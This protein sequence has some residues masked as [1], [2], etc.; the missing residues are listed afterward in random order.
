MERL[1]RER[2]TLSR[3]L[4]QSQEALEEFRELH[5]SE[6]SVA[7]EREQDLVADNAALRDALAS[8][9]EELHKLRDAF[10]KFLAVREAH[11]DAPQP[12]ADPAW[13]ANAFEQEYDSEELEQDAFET[14][15][16]QAQGK[17]LLHARQL[18]IDLAKQLEQAT[19]TAE[20]IQE[21]RD[22]ALVLLQARQETIE[23]LKDDIQH[24]KHEQ[25]QDIELEAVRQQVQ[26]TITAQTNAVGTPELTLIHLQMQT[27]RNI[28]LNDLLQHA[29]V[30]R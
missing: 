12:Q 30:P 8:R 14:P 25:L 13:K 28:N 24:L 20:Q 3:H 6:L 21:Q 15:Y 19:Q 18:A 26:R 22:A 1:A 9:D 23:G 17:K 11:W 4:R 29:P 10:D 2:D 7:Q 5:E 27:M 16:I